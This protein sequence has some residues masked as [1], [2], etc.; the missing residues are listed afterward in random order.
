MPLPVMLGPVQV[1][2]GDIVFADETGIVIIPHA[3]KAA[4]LRQAAEIREAEDGRRV[5]GP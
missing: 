1:N 3:Q 2:P 4:V 5:Q